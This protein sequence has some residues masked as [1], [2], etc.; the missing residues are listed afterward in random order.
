MTDASWLK[1]RA[2]ARVADVTVAK[3]RHAHEH[4]IVVAIDEDALDAQPVP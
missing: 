2:I 4:G 1:Q 3:P